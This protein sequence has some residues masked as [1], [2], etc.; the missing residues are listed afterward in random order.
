M[1]L[2]GAFSMYDKQTV[3]YSLYL[4]TDRALSLGRRSIEIIKAAVEGGELL[5]FSCEKKRP[6]RKNFTKRDWR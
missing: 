2:M 4:V 5:L 3:D 1:R 6:Q